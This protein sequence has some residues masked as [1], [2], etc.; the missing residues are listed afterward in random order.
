MSLSHNKANNKANIFCMSLKSKEGCP[1]IGRALRKHILRKNILENI[2]LKFGTR[3]IE[4]ILVGLLGCGSLH[5]WELEVLRPV[6]IAVHWQKLWDSKATGSTKR[7]S[8]EL[9]RHERHSGQRTFLAYLGHLLSRARTG[10][11]VGYLPVRRVGSLLCLAFCHCAPLAAWG[12]GQ[13]CKEA[14]NHC[15]HI[16]GGG[17]KRNSP[18]PQPTL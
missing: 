17:T 3:W 4:A 18:S 9:R 6:C 5:V 16:R 11:G 10:F 1:H 14:E 7:S 8:L 12:E 15:L 2:L 13:S